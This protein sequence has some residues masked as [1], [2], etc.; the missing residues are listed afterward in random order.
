MRNK[1]QLIRLNRLDKC[2]KNFHREYSIYDLLEE[3]NDALQQYDSKGSGIQLR[4]LRSDISFMRNSQGYGA[5]IEVYLGSSGNYYR[6]SDKNFSI[7]NSPLNITEAEQLK[8]AL[9]VLQRF[10]GSPQFE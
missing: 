6:Y 4:T 5:P 10:E 9:S 8:A 2:F 1:P 7:S 3:V